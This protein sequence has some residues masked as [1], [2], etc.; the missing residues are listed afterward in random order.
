[1]TLGPMMG[2][3]L[4]AAG[5]APMPSPKVGIVA[6]PCAELPR[7]SPPRA[8]LE[9][10][11]SD[12]PTLNA[13][14]RSPAEI[15]ASDAVREAQLRYDWANMCR[16][17]AANQALPID[18]ERVVFIGNSITEFWAVADPDMF[19][20]HNVNRGI[21]GQVTAQTLVR[22]MADVVALKPAVVHIWSGTNDIAGNGGPTTLAAIEANTRAM[23]AIAKA[24]NI[25]VV[26]GSI[27]PAREFGWRRGLNPAAQIA[28]L[29]GR[30]KILAAENGAVFADYYAVLNDGM[31]GM[32]G[33][34]SRDGVHP[35]RIAY[36]ALR[37]IAERAIMR[38]QSHVKQQTQR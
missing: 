37:P 13:P 32:N 24:N 35:N 20:R 9:W 27:T 23:I 14:V 1:M 21:S 34:F 38:A 4:L 2:L 11:L 17:R 26:I 8:Y 28:A 16:Y 12:D 7:H 31:G 22:F 5:D 18:A 36:L 10:L 15:A 33:R 6:D 29:N 30:L 3:L 25:A 19:A